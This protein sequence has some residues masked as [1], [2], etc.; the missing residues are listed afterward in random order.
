MARG[1]CSLATLWGRH[2]EQ[3]AD[4]SQIAIRHIELF[5]DL[6][7]WLGPYQPVKF[8]PQNHN[9]CCLQRVSLR[10]YSRFDVHE[11][12]PFLQSA[13]CPATVGGFWWDAA[14]KPFPAKEE[15]SL[16]TRSASSLAWKRTAMCGASSGGFP[17]AGKHRTNTTVLVWFRFSLKLR[18]NSRRRVRTQK[19]ENR[20]GNAAW[21][22]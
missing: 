15:L 2:I 20:D 19:Q 12:M 10:Q 3:S 11:L 1:R 13:L 18:Q 9:F 17:S 4:Y 8:I 16:R 5:G 21:S 7:H 6:G 14:R 22:P